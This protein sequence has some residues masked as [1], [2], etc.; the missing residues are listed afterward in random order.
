VK[1]YVFTFTFY[2]LRHR[3]PC[4]GRPVG[5][6]K[7]CVYQRRKI[8][9][10]CRRVKLASVARRLAIP[11]E[12][13]RV[14]HRPPIEGASRRCAPW[15]CEDEVRFGRH[16]PWSPLQVMTSAFTVAPSARDPAA[17]ST[18]AGSVVGAGARRSPGRR[19]S[20]LSVTCRSRRRPRVH[21][22]ARD[23]VLLR[24]SGR[25]PC[26]CC[27]RWNVCSPALPGNNVLCAVNVAVLCRS[28]CRTAHGSACRVA[29]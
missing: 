7:N 5:L 26:C 20:L 6:P 22:G 13:R 1:S 4:A 11:G 29:S 8:L 14:N 25:P 16:R 21:C 24:S 15:R 23:H 19:R 2:V 3:P 10:A 12:V 28:V 27:R 17:K 9:N 18:S